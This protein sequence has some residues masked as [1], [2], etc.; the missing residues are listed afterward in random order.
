[1]CST[2]LLSSMMGDRRHVFTVQKFKNMMVV[3][4]AHYSFP[5]WCDGIFSPH[6]NV[7]TNTTKEIDIFH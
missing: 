2:V 3:V 6:L 1:M 7:A 5:M 4:K